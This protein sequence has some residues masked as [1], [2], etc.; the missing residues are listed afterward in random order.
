MNSK[1]GINK[2]H[3]YIIPTY[4]GFL[5]QIVYKITQGYEYVHIG[6]LDLNKKN[7]FEKIDRKIIDQYIADASTSRRYNNKK[8]GRANFVYYRHK[9]IY[10]IMM[11]TQK[12]N[13]K[14]TKTSEKIVIT[15]QFN[16][17]EKGDKL[18]ITFND[19]REFRIGRGEDDKVTV[20]MSDDMY[21]DVAAR[22]LSHNDSK[23]FDYVVR[24]F[25]KLNGLPAWQGINRQRFKLKR[26]LL[27][28]SQFKK[29]ELEAYA[30]RF[31]IWT[32]RTN[33]KVFEG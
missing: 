28:Q 12:F 1:R 25:N 31:K 21:N 15:E 10:I 7:K 3:K 20:F 33:V 32:K 16:H 30:E 24:D 19:Y 26:R 27:K 2:E 5:Q 17:F 8:S 22:L 6:Y 9:N 4:V 18:V 23:R 14:E 29:K 11:A 13:G